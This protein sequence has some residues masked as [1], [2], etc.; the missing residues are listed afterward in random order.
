MWS[1]IGIGRTFFA[2]SRTM[3]KPLAAGCGTTRANGTPKDSRVISRVCPNFFGS[4]C[5]IASVFSLI[6]RMQRFEKPSP[7]TM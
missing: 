4:T 2:L 3:A 5:E 7:P 1:M 6:R